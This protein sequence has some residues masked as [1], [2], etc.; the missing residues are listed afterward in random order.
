VPNAFTPG[1]PGTRGKNNIV[2]PE[3]FGI[4]KVIF[5]IYNRWGQKLFETTTPYQGW[6]CTFKGVIQPMDV[7]VYTLEV[8]FSDGTKASKRGDITLIR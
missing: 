8:E 5:R 7:Y 1:R 4:E 2:K 3:G 6:D